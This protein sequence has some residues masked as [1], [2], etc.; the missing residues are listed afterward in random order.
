MPPFPDSGTAEINLSSLEKRE[1]GK[2]TGKHSS[3]DI[4]IR[5][6]QY[7]SSK[8]HGET[9]SSFNINCPFSLFISSFLLFYILENK[10]QLLLVQSRARGPNAQRM[11]RY[12]S[13]VHP[14]TEKHIEQHK[15]SLEEF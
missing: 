4:T 3:T 6:I 5:E 1:G 9:F 11:P 13:G 2:D 8:L 15:F 14:I 12:V 7:F 10:K